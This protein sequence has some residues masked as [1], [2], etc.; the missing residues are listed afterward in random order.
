MRL[1]RL[2]LAVLLVPECARAQIHPD[3]AWVDCVSP[4]PC[5][6]LVASSDWIKAGTDGK[7]QG[8]DMTLILDVEDCSAI[9]DPMRASC[10]R[11]QFAKKQPAAPQPPQIVQH[12]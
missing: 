8:A 6:A 7:D 4:R 2:V 11:I 1:K 9:G 5:Y 12:H 10:Q 3:P